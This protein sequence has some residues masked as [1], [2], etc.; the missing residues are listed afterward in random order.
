M[1]FPRRN[2]SPYFQF[3][4]LR[5]SK[6]TVKVAFYSAPHKVCSAQLTII[7]SQPLNP[8]CLKGHDLWEV[9]KYFFSQAYPFTYV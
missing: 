2:A 1:D 6:Q 8:P 5:K 9:L 4:Q 7:P 3:S